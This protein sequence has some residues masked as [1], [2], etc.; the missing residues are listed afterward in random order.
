MMTTFGLAA[1]GKLR[2]DTRPQSMLVLL[3]VS[4]AIAFILGVSRF[5]R[6]LSVGLPLGALIGFQA[7]RL[8][9]EVLLHRA[10]SDGLMPIQM[11]FSGRNFDILT[12]GTA[13][14]ITAAMASNFRVSN[15]LLWLWNCMGIA[16]LLNV[17]AI[18]L[19]SMPTPIRRFHNDPPNTWIAQPPYVWLPTV[20]VVLAMAGHIVITRKLLARDLKQ[21]S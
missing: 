16:L 10:Y 4:F 11:S 2:F 19:L 7:F 8:P 17:L 20:F 3:V 1:S 12:G 9:L 6:Q 14:L 21:P 13:V 5:G 18:A 15:A